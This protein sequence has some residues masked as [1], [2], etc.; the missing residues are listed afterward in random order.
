MKEKEPHSIV[1]NAQA[2]YEPSQSSPSTQRFIWNYQ[3]TIVNQSDDYV[4]LLSR[5]WLITDMTGRIEEVVGTGVVGLQPL[6]KPKKQFTYIS[7]CQLPTP[8]G[9]MEGYFE[10]QN[11]EEERFRI[12]VPKFILSAPSS[13]T[14]SFRSILH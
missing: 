5:Y 12:E 11:L 8:Q 10:M 4:Q 13:I 1:V 3:I 9:T 7:Y 2:G 6:I 14:Q